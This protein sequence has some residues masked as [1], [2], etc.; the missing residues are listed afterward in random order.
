[1]RTII[2]A[3]VL[4]VVAP[5]TGWSQTHII[6][7]QGQ[8]TSVRTLSGSQSSSPVNIG[9]NSPS[10]GSNIPGPAAAPAIAPS[11]YGG[12]SCSLGDSAAV[13][14][15]GFGIGIGHQHE[16]TA[17]N[18]N[19]RAALLYNMGMKQAANEYICAKDRDSYNAMKTAGTPCAVR[20]EWEP[21]VANPPATP[22]VAQAAP[23]RAGCPVYEVNGQRFVSCPA[24]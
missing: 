2:L 3:A 20:P 7:A 8:N 12:S 11:I 18:E 1:M 5:A 21:K 4:A 15:L 13:Q 24:Q 16:S 23:V 6:D 14:G 19:Q 9:N 10:Y 17:C 22:V